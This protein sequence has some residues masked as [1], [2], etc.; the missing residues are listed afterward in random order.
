MFE[1]DYIMRQLQILSQALVRAFVMRSQGQLD[2]AIK[3]LDK[4]FAAYTEL[5]SDRF[6]TL[7]ID[8]MIALCSQ[9]GNFS[10][11]HGCV[12]GNVLE[13]QGDLL[14]ERGQERLADGNYIRALG[15]YLEALSEPE[16]PIPVDL[17][18]RIAYL[19]KQTRHVSYP[20]PIA[21]RL[22]A[23]LTVRTHYADAED[24]LFHWLDDYPDDA[25]DAGWE[26]FAR[27][28]SRS[29]RELRQGGLS[30]REVR[31]AMQ[32]FKDALTSS[33]S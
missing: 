6:H 19:I 29:D 4:A 2:D 1:R 30:K 26:F 12:L 24:L 10:V 32:A 8:Q 23:Y 9:N 31:E 5:E 21:K 20:S 18:E 27:L 25:T 7:T 33:A 3:E 22:L 16:A 11:E 28:L 17:H 13:E 14:L 15:L